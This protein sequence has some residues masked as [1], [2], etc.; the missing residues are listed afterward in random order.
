MEPNILVLYFQEIIRK[1]VGISGSGNKYAALAS[2]L[3]TITWENP[4]HS[5][6]QQLARYASSISDFTCNLF[7]RSSPVKNNNGLLDS[8]LVSSLFELQF[9]NMLCI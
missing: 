9:W 3:G 2:A 8:G 4:Q 1:Y 6:F 5:E 7:H